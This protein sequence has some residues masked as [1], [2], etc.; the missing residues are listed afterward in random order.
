[1]CGAL[2]TGLLPVAAPMAGIVGFYLGLGNEPREQYRPGMKLIFR[3]ASARG[4][5]Q[6]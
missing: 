5:G 6:L 4:R 3:L 1:M 2:L